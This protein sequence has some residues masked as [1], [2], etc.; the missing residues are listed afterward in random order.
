MRDFLWTSDSVPETGIPT[1][2]SKYEVVKLDSDKDK[3]LTLNTGKLQ[4]FHNCDP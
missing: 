3:Y 1:D 2:P 4:S